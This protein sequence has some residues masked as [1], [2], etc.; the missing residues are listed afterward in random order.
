MPNCILQ[1]I[2]PFLLHNDAEPAK[3]TADTYIA[4]ILAHVGRSV[5]LSPMRMIIGT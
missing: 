1:I 4:P 5:C 3:Q 2:P